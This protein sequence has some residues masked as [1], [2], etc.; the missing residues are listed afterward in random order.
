M[1]LDS[2]RK[3]A[4]LLAWLGPETAAELLKEAEPATVTRLAAE[5]ATLDAS[6]PVETE[7]RDHAQ[8]FYAM[9]RGDSDPKVRG[10]ALVRAVLETVF[11]R[12][13]MAEMMTQ[14]QQMLFARDPFRVIRSAGAVNIANALKGEG[15]QVASLV[16]SELPPKKSADVLALL[17]EEIQD[18]AIRTMTGGE[19]V[20]SEARLRVANVVMARLRGE[21]GPPGDRKRQEQL[22]RVALVLRGMP[23]GSRDTLL[24]S[25]KQNDPE[26]GKEVQD[27]ML[28]WEDVKNVSGRAIQA[29]LRS[30]DSRKLA[31]A[32]FEAD[33]KTVDKIRGNISARMSAM[34]DEEKS[35]LSTPNAEDI[36]GAREP[37][38]DALREMNNEGQLSFEDDEDA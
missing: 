11:G 1:E 37:I 9:L 20:S 30:V 28:V 16:L 24:E 23:R 32:L 22:R 34:V 18:G 15:A 13:R 29:A 12:Q 21:S 36:E 25:I 10:E 6:T 4:M 27:L 3:A 7:S 8:E 31:L 35:L 38:L 33:Q 14:I 26:A 17:A 5:M 2:A 19:E